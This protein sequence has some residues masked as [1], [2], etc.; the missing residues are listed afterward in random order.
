VD[1]DARKTERSIPARK[2]PRGRVERR[3]DFG[4]L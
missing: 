1:K 2:P 4:Y 3:D